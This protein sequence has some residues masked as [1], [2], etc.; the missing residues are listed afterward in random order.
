MQVI[1]SHES[2]I[3]FWLTWGDIYPGVPC[4]VP[5]G[6]RLQLSAAEIPGLALT[7]PLHVLI[8]GQEQRRSDPLRCH[9]LEK[10]PPKSLRQVGN[11]IYVVCPELAFMQLAAASARDERE[12]IVRGTQ[13]CSQYSLDSTKENGLRPHA[14]HSSTKAIADFAAANPG[15][16]GAHRAFQLGKRLL[17]GSRSPMEGKLGLTMG[18]PHRLGGY[19][20]A[21]FEM[22]GIVQLSNKGEAMLRRPSC[23]CD[24]IWRK[25]GIVLEYDSDQHHSRQPDLK[26]DTRRREALRVSGLDVTVVT[27]DLFNSYTWMDELAR[28]IMKARTGRFRAWPDD[29]R[30]RQSALRRALLAFD[31]QRPAE[32]PRKTRGKRVVPAGD[33]TQNIEISGSMLEAARGLTQKVEISGSPSDQSTVVYYALEFKPDED[34]LG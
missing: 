18:L 17:D 1:I 8:A 3:E 31:S 6:Y 11:G 25:L 34:P 26:R 13:L 7:M 15:L 23:E 14:P 29:F 5:R 27:G 33:L 21:D 20:E 16:R 10:L 22:N 2:A 9:I 19:S 30:L 32:L 24:L 28:R 12:L 4:S